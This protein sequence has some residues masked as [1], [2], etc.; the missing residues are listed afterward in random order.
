MP[1][2]LAFKKRTTCEKFMTLLLSS[3]LLLLSS[4]I[5]VAARCPHSLCNV[6]VL[7]IKISPVCH[8]IKNGLIIFSL[9]EKFMIY[10]SFVCE[11]QG[12]L[13]SQ[14]YSLLIS[15][16]KKLS[17]LYIETV[18]IP[19]WKETNLTNCNNELPKHI[20]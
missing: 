3:L 8:Q 12:G 6:H 20:F 19:G 17:R 11:T 15:N 10:L 16:K 1:L 2:L 5:S 13:V 18:T 7:Q 9:Y 4:H 14:I